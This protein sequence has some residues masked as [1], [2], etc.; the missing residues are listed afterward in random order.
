M[1][2]RPSTEAAILGRMTEAD[3]APFQAINTD[4]WPKVQELRARREGLGYVR[5]ARLRE[6]CG[7]PSSKTPGVANT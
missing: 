7:S 2:E 1:R 6:S 5:L 3:A 4:P